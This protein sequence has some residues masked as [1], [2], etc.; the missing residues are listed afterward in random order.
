MPSCLHLDLYQLTSLL[1]HHQAGA[2]DIPVTMSFFSRKLPQNEA[3]GQTC[4]PYLLQVALGRCLQW[5]AGARFDAAQLATLARHP[6]LGPRLSPDLLKRLEQWHFSGIIDA[7]LDG[8]L[9]VAGKA[10]TMQGKPVEING[11]KP[12]AWCPYLVVQTD[13]LSAKLIETPL[14]S[15]LNHMTMVASKAAQVVVAAKGRPVYEFGSRRTHPE[16]AVDAAL[17]AYIA[18]AAGTSNM[19]ANHRYGIPALGTMDHFA[20]QSWEKP[21]VPR[22][23]TELAF[24]KAFYALYGGGTLL[25]DTYDTF[26][27]QTGIVN[28]VKAA[29]EK[30]TGIRIDSGISI[31]SVTRARAL[32]DRL[33]APQAKILLSGGLDEQAIL[34][35][36][37]APADAFGI[38]ERI[39]TSPDAPVGVGAVAKL[40]EVEGRPTMKF[41]KG[42][43]KATLPGRL[44]VFRADEQDPRQDIIGLAGEN[45]PGRPLLMRVWEGR[46]PAYD[47][48][49]E[50]ARLRAQAAIKNTISSLEPASLRLSDKLLNLIQNLA[51]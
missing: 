6:Q 33:G 46:V 45:L 26:G 30:L 22:A 38:G 36:G 15:L 9:L 1:V 3:T 18:G 37:S 34:E 32:L 39:V 51:G 19:E 7:P 35:L 42:S 17:A 44:Q 25:V 16:A 47:P 11:I 50:A 28:A 41:S 31:E 23:E 10:V 49:P 29:G 2:S 12:S 14:L 21:G 20:I 24:F 5:L 48:N 40:G 8:S 4:R 13:L 27:E 43:G